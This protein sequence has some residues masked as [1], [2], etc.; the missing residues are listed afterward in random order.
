MT[1]HLNVIP[2]KHLCDQLGISRNTIKRWIEYRGFPKPLKA[3]GQE[4]LFD[5]DAVN[6]WFEKYG[7][8]VTMAGRVT[9]KL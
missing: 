4:P 9:A 3:S 7:P 5:S 8:L 2:R 6:L 1:Q